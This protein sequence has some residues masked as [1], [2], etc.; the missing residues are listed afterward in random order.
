METQLMALVA[1]GQ[2]GRA[3]LPSSEEHI[4]I[5]TQATPLDIPDTDLPERALGFRVQLYGMIKHR[6]KRVAPVI[7]QITVLVEVDIR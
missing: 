6:E 5:A 4:E 3:Y 2:R 7:L 1:E